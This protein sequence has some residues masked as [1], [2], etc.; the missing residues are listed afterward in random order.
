M[1]TMH[2]S[3]VR[4]A[5]Y[6]DCKMKV[7]ADGTVSVP[8]YVADYLRANGWTVMSDDLPEAVDL[9]AALAD[10]EAP[11]NHL[12]PWLHACGEL[13]SAMDDAS[14]LREDALDLY[15]RGFGPRP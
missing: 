8:A 12:F 11:V 1:I 5:V 2:K 13:F 15:D 9:R 3:G 10:E 14:D 4:D 6:G 7:E